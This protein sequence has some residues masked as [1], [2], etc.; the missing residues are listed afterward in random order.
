MGW[1]RTRCSGS[2]WSSCESGQKQALVS[3]RKASGGDVPILPHLR[4]WG[5]RASLFVLSCPR[6]VAHHCAVCYLLF[7]TFSLPPLLP[8]EL[9]RKYPMPV[10]IVTWSSTGSD[11]KIYSVVQHTECFARVSNCNIELW[12]IARCHDFACAGT[13]GSRPHP[14]SSDALCTDLPRSFFQQ[15][16]LCF[17]AL[18]IVTVPCRLQVNMLPLT[19]RVIGLRARFVELY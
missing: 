19:F 3:Q 17:E 11:M 9:Y 1:K 6:L 12:S 15:Q 16:L 5:F 8:L 4:S 18:K 13:W 14:N 2:S 7:W 10:G